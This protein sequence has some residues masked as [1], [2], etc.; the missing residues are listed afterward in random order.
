MPRISRFHVVVL[1]LML[2]LITGWL[3]LDHGRDPNGEGAALSDRPGSSRLSEAA[4]SEIESALVSQDPQEVTSIFAE[5]VAEAYADDGV[6][7]PAGSAVSVAR[8]ALQVDGSTATV[9]ITV[10][11]PEPGKWLLLLVKEDGRW[12]AY[13]TRSM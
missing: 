12:R 6:L 13:G 11:G 7:L 1:G 9:P 8:N 2:A 10:S 4:A 3:L 5:V